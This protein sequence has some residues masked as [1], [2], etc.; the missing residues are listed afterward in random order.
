MYKAIVWCNM[1]MAVHVNITLF[2]Q[3]HSERTDLFIKVAH[4]NHV[5]RLP[6]LDSRHGDPD[7]PQKVIQLFLKL[8]FS[9]F[10]RW[11]FANKKINH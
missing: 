7:Q 2:Q 8:F 9:K 5:P 11:V 6:D 3:E 10:L 1:L 4:D